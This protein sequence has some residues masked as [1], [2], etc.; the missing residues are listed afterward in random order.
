MGCVANSLRAVTSR[1]KRHGR[2]EGQVI[3]KR[4]DRRRGIVDILVEEG[5][6]T[7]DRLALHFGVSKMTIH[8]DLDELEADGLLRR[9][10]GGATIE[11]SGQFES[12]FRYRA[13]M[14]AA[15]KRA[16]AARAADFVQPGMCV[17]VDDGSTAGS[18]VPFLRE[19]RPLTVVT[20]NMAVIAGLAGEAGIELIALG[21]NYSKK[22]N[23][24]FGVVTETALA[25]L[26]ADVV[27]LSSSSIEGRTAF[28]QDQ[29][30]LAVK[31]RMIASSA[32]SYL[33]VDHFKFGR[34]A[35]HLFTDLGVFDGVVTSQAL[36]REQAAALEEDG[37]RLYLA[38]EDA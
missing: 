2:S 3:V 21:G 10:R 28:H 14:A 24:F 15:E 5:A 35:L 25:A 23:G 29:E 4:D 26:R 16:I 6:A 30:V 37:I 32:E 33:M 8:R 17:M 36:P 31:R 12:D 11:A 20:N 1:L 22:F 18:L 9:T 27:L 19:K 7:L 13:R 38:E 34:T